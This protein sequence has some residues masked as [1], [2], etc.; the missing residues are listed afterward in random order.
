MIRKKSIMFE[1]FKKIEV[2][3]DV[4]REAL[5]NLT[6]K[7]GDLLLFAIEEK[8]K[9]NMVKDLEVLFTKNQAVS[10]ATTY[11]KDPNKFVTMLQSSCNKRAVTVSDNKH[12]DKSHPY[13]GQILYS[14]FGYDC[15]LINFYKV[16]KVTAKTV[17]VQQI[18]STMVETT[19][20]GYGQQGYVRP[21]PDKFVEGS[22]PMRR[23][24]KHYSKDSFT[25]SISDYQSAEPWNGEDIYEDTMN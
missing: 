7:Q 2:S 4:T 25:I 16:T 12:P 10:I 1:T 9:E 18:E 15:T 14:S 19:D 21:I 3:D 13:V 20:G 17:V 24:I 11:A 6:S 5:N 22:K 8:T 23:R